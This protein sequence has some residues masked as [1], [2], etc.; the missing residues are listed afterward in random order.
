M[1]S[2]VV[3]ILI[4]L[5]SVVISR[6]EILNDIPL[7]MKEGAVLEYFG[8]I[9]SADN[10]RYFTRDNSPSGN[11]VSHTLVSG[12]VGY[13]IIGIPNV[14]RYQWWPSFGRSLS[15]IVV[16]SEDRSV[17]DIKFFGARGGWP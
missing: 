7:G 16:L 2:N 11:T 5:M 9:T 1:T 10:I 13:Y 12:E 4:M 15:V 8:D 6:E 3:F 14:Q 17:T